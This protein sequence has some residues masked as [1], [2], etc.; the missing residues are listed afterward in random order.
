MPR[1]VKATSTILLRVGLL[2]ANVT[3]SSN[4]LSTKDNG[5]MTCF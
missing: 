1:T 2:V 4:R 3:D 5:V